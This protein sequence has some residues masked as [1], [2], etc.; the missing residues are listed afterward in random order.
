MSRLMNDS[1][2]NKD[3]NVQI[4]DF[5]FHGNDDIPLF[6]SWVGYGKPL[7]ILH[8][9][10]PDRQSIIPFAKLLADDYRVI[11]PDIRG[12]G[13]SICTDRTKHNWAQYAQDVI[14]LMD[15]LKLTTA[16]IGGMGLG[17]SIAERI[18]ISYANRIEA[19][20]LISPE[21][22]DEDGEGSST[23]EIAM[24]ERCSQVAIS[25]GLEEAWKPFMPHLTPVINSM[26]KEAMPRMN[27]HSFSA[28]MAIVYSKRLESS[29]QL[30]NISA[31]T[32]VIPGNDTRHAS[33]IGKTYHSLISK[34]FIGHEVNW[35]DIQTVDQFA[36]YVAP[37][38]RS[39]L[40]ENAI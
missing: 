22:L 40:N 26:V 31:P 33:D 37:Q 15:H 20:I 11:F 35:N 8:G 30:L 24:M 34:C 28:A 3:G 19:L 29:N 23:Q 27:A 5:I 38:I 16:I 18:A 21:T 13:Q 1:L 14:S 25:E 39:F 12:Y 32:L 6:A 10:G 9:G 7:I 36:A 17:A 4:N 2:Y